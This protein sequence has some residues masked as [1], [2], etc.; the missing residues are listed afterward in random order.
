MFKR[1]NE[2]KGKTR[3]MSGWVSPVLD[4]HGCSLAAE[5]GPDVNHEV[6]EEGGATG[7]DGRRQKLLDEEC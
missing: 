2:V 3:Q 1:V 7:V 4:S 5:L 6:E